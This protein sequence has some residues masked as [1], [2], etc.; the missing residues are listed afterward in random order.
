MWIT[1]FHGIIF[2]LPSTKNGFGD[3]FTNSSGHS[4]RNYEGAI[5]CQNQPVDQ[6][7]GHAEE[8]SQ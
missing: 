4:G 5:D 1:F 6:K 8:N 3:F 2:V 7:L